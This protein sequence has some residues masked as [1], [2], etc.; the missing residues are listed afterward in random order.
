MPTLLYPQHNCPYLTLSHPL[1]MSMPHSLTSLMSLGPVSL[2]C[3]Q[4]DIS[5]VQTDHTISN[6]KSVIGP[7]PQAS[8]PWGWIRMPKHGFKNNHDLAVAY[9]VPNWLSVL[10][11]II[12][13][14]WQ[15]LGHRSSHFPQSS[16]VCLHISLWLMPLFSLTTSGLSL[17][18]APTRIHQTH[19]P[20]ANPVFPS[21]ILL[22]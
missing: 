16:P 14:Y 12:T 1:P 13:H 7:P 18:L 5:K 3:I 4:G 17:E 8:F 20:P 11:L 15:S 19:A 6:L 9:P 10:A 2:N 21:H 22:L